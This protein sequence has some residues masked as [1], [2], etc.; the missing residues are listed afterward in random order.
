MRRPLHV[1]MII[2]LT[3]EFNKAPFN[4]N[5]Q[6]IKKGLEHDLILSIY[7]LNFFNQPRDVIKSCKK[8]HSILRKS[9]L[10]EK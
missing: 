10:Q 2:Q 8:S 5:L 7:K 6:N 3:K 4:P 9:I 1:Q